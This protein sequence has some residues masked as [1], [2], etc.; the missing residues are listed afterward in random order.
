MDAEAGSCLQGAVGADAL[1][2]IWLS[3]VG[4]GARSLACAPARAAKSAAVS[5]LAPPPM[6]ATRGPAPPLSSP[7]ARQT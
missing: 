4:V 3:G 5:P 6:T 7:S 1:V 2:G